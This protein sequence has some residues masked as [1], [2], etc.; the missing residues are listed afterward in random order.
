MRNQSRS[1]TF[2]FV[3]FMA[4]CGGTRPAPPSAD[5]KTEAPHSATYAVA[6]DRISPRG[7]L[8]DLRG[9]QNLPAGATVI[10]ERSGAETNGDAWEEVARAATFDGR[11]EARSVALRS[12]N[13]LVAAVRLRAHARFRAENAYST[14][15]QVA[16]PSVSVA[17]RVGQALAGAG[18]VCDI[19]R[20][21][22]VTVS[23]RATNVLPGDALWIGALVYEP[24]MQ[25]LPH[26]RD[27]AIQ[28]GQAAMQGSTAEWE[29]SIGIGQ[30]HRMLFRGGAIS[31]P[32]GG[33]VE[34][35]RDYSGPGA[36]VEC[37]AR[38]RGE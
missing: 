18:R 34:Q 31:V 25:L 9:T 8:A 3:A 10:I 21:A 2:L 28:A 27:W 24:E 23:L 16:V 17:V 32:P 4:A 22:Q 30:A 11:W 6:I 1:L 20:D 19:R 7:P 13:S 26:P 36:F 5:A 35:F 14:S 15:E 33:S 37:A 38:R 29:R 12:E